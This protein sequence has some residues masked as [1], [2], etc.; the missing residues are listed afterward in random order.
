M[1]T[2]TDQQGAL[3]SSEAS[4]F[5][6]VGNYADDTDFGSAIRQGH[7][8]TGANPINPGESHMVL[9][10]RSRFL[11]DLLSFTA[12]AAHQE[13]QEKQNEEDADVEL[14]NDYKN[15]T[16]EELLSDE[17]I[18]KRVFSQT[19][20][21]IPR[22]D[23]FV[24]ETQVQSY[25]EFVRKVQAILDDAAE[26]ESNSKPVDPSTSAAAL[27]PATAAQVQGQQQQQ[28]W[29]GWGVNIALRTATLGLVGTNTFSGAGGQND[30]TEAALKAALLTK[31]LPPALTFTL[32]TTEGQRT[33][34]RMAVSCA[35]QGA[36]AIMLDGVSAQFYQFDDVAVG[37]VSDTDVLPPNAPTRRSC[38]AVKT[39]RVGSPVVE[40]R[41]LLR[42]F[43]LLPNGNASTMFFVH[44]LLTVPLLPQGRH[45]VCLEWKV[46]TPPIPQLPAHSSSSSQSQ[47]NQ[48]RENSTASS[49]SASNSQQQPEP[50][51]LI[52]AEQ[53]P[54]EEK[55]QQTTRVLSDEE[56]ARQLQVQFDAEEERLRK[57]QMERDRELAKSL[58]PVHQQKND[59]QQ[60]QNNNTNI[61]DDNN[62]NDDDELGAITEISQEQEQTLLEQALTARRRRNKRQNNY[63]HRYGGVYGGGSRRRSQQ[64]QSNIASS[65]QEEEEEEE[66]STSSSTTGRPCNCLGASSGFHRPSCP[67]RTY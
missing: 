43:R 12:E 61:N 27:T 37:E 33:A 5:L 53:L 10:S 48:Q 25:E 38:I 51:P 64:Q 13:Q 32:K 54:V 4:S 46:T 65:R 47:E 15:K 55:N 20:L 16:G 50:I 9:L 24:G 23:V 52:L 26:D 58:A 41:K 8:S 60:Q 22:Q 19:L 39:S 11:H 7:T 45:E 36:L 59:S 40:V 1:S 14:V 57:L 67:L 3:P 29:V 31:N 30:N 21:D 49:S 62:D 2:T 17:E 44:T 63:N 56:V 66:S 28:G 34:L 6:V 18:W 42:L 35:Q